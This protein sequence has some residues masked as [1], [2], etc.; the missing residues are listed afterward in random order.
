MVPIPLSQERLIPAP[1]VAV[2]GEI[3]LAHGQRTNQTTGFR[4][5]ACIYPLG[6]FC[7]ILMELNFT[8]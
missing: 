1:R 7:Y 6:L 2:V 8:G 5:F 3:M 4:G